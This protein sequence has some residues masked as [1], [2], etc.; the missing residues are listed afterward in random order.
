MNNNRTFK[1]TILIDL[2]GVLNVYDGNFNKN[3]IPPIKNGA[4]SFLENLSENYEIKI[5]TT[6]NKILTAKWLS[7]NDIDKFVEDVTNVKE[8]CWLYI[9]DRAVTF[10]GDFEKLKSDIATFK[11]WYK[12]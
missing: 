5:F 3:V 7:D 10:N 9:D 1:K 6:R 8:L 2:D 4:K 12:N 11:P